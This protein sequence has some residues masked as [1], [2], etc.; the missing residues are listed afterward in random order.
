MMFNTFE[1]DKNLDLHKY[2]Q[3]DHLPD[4][5]HVKV[6]LSYFK[7]L[8]A[9]DLIINEKISPIISGTIFSVSNVSEE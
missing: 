2:P 6:Y 8:I 9:I 7:N 3:S 5:S 4:K 1:T